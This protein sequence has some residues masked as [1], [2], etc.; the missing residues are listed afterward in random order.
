MIGFEK[1]NT[2]MLCALASVPL[3]K[4]PSDQSEMVSQILAG[5]PVEILDEAKKYWI[6]VKCLGD[7]YIGYA[8]PR[9]F[10]LPSKGGETCIVLHDDISEWREKE[11]GAIHLFSAGSAF[12]VS[13]DRFFIG[14]KEFAR[15]GGEG[16][17]PSTLLETAKKY[18]GTPY[19]WGGRARTGIDC[20]GLVQI[21]AKLLEIYLPRDAKDQA[22]EGTEVVWDL[23]AQND[24]AFFE[25]ESGKITHV[26][27][28]LDPNTVIHASAEVRIDQLSEGGIIHSST[29]DQT[30]KLH[31][32]RR[33]S[34]R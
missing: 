22:L 18:L 21:S 6:K 19:L 12:T 8:D 23:R 25:N 7:G 11:T 5:E 3:R 24:L 26:A 34:L 14:D 29:L 32:I 2:M 33:I 28:L 20:S 17:K 31:S 16:L 15:L 30:H 1:A 13:N 27:I 10:T 4:E 9:H